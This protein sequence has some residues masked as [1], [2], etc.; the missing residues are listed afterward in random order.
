MIYR[1]FQGMKL[2]ALGMGGMPTLG[3]R[4]GISK[5]HGFGRKKR[6]K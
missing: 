1:S 4:G 3:K 2:S 5:M 6:L